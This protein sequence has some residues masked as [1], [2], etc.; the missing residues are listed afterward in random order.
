M[1][2]IGTFIGWRKAIIGVAV[3]GLLTVAPTATA[4]AADFGFY[5]Y[6][7]DNNGE[8]DLSA[9]DSNGD[10]RYD[11][12]L[13]D[14]DA[15]DRQNGD[16]WLIDQNENGVADQVAADVTGDLHADVWLLDRNEDNT[17]E[18]VFLD[19]NRDFLPDGVNLVIQPYVPAGM[20]DLVITPPRFGGIQDI[21]NGL[22]DGQT[23]PCYGYTWTLPD[24][25]SC[26]V[27]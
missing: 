19:E 25:W 18:Q 16:T 1:S 24:G 5:M 12:N 20:V 10:D 13:V 8:I 23:S 17:F 9:I 15:H 26:K 2:S 11:Q 27:Q 3:A 6:D 7:V 21:A 22:M 4:N 14:I